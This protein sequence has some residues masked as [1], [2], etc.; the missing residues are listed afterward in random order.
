MDKKI[1]KIHHC[2]YCGEETEDWDELSNG[3]I[4]YVCGDNL[5]Q[6]ELREINREIDAEAI[7]RADEDG[8]SKY[9]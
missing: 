6:R 1:E 7:D 3:R 8:Y 2:F 5:C 4:I 9:Y